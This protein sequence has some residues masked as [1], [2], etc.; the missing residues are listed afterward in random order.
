[1]AETIR[2]VRPTPVSTYLANPHKGICTFQGFNGDDLFPGMTWPE[3]GPT[4][5]IAPRQSVADGYLPATVAY[6]RW[7]WRTLE[8]AE[9]KYDFTPIDRALEICAERGQTLS[10][11]LMPF[12]SHRQ[13][14]VPEWY[15][16]KYPMTEHKHKSFT[17]RIPVHSSAEYLAGY[18]ALIKEVGKRYDG[19]PLLETI[20]MAYIGPWGEG[21]GECSDEQCRNFAELFRD[22]FPRTPRLALIEGE[23]MRAGLATGSGWRADCFGDLRTYG[24]PFVTTNVTWNHMYDA[25]PKETHEGGARDTWRTSPVFFESCFVPLYWYEHGFDIDFIIE[26]GLKYHATYFNPKSTRIPEKWM[27][28]LA[29]FSRKMGYRYIYR[30]ALFE[31][32]PKA[33]GVMRF[34]SWIENVGV[35]PIYRRYEFVLRLRQGDQEELIILDDDARTWLPGDV[36]VD[37]TIELPESIKA[38]WVDI[39]AGLVDPVSHDAKISFANKEVFSDRWISLGATEVM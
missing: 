8:P 28:K 11:R 33:R 37:R 4:E 36:F 15:D 13:A 12:G 32:T 38:G 27:D 3:D 30:Q 25:Y 18:G 21:A 31:T 5:F 20:D 9:G 1:M 34:Q 14:Q 19:H 17:L 26:Q 39:A 2:R 22:A 24:S 7:F 29:A 23:Q 6:C 35:A 10:L 16:R